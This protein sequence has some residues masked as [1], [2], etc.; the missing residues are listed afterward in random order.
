MDEQAIIAR[1]RRRGAAGNFVPT[2]HA[3]D[4][5]D[6]ESI[7]FIEMRQAL[8]TCQ[9]LE[10][11]FDARRGPCCLVYGVAANDRPLHMVCTSV[12]STLEIITVYEPKPPRWATPTQRG[13]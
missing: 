13:K 5:M 9:M 7:S 8:A 12:K 11:Y 1:I 6:D 4:E 10:D 3:R 2:A